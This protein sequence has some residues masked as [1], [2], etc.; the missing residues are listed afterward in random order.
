MCVLVEWC[1][2][3]IAFINIFALIVI[4][5]EIRALHFPSSKID[6]KDR[7]NPTKVVPLERSDVLTRESAFLA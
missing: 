5:L 4:L 2:D 1:L 6:P 7:F 3:L